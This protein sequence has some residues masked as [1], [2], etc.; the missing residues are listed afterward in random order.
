[1]G[2]LLQRG[3]TSTKSENPVDPYMMPPSSM[4][5][6]L[7]HVSLLR[8]MTSRKNV[9]CVASS[10]RGRRYFRRAYA[11]E[12]PSITYPITCADSKGLVVFGTR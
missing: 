3:N 12:S 11:T 8:V 5:R 10:V 4:L 7:L 6:Q 2:P 1:M 9:S